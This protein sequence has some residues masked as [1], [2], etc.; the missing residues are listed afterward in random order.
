VISR[1]TIIFFLI[2]V[3]SFAILTYR[4]WEQER[5]CREWKAH[6]FGQPEPAPIRQPDGTVSVTL[7]PCGLWYAMPLVDMLLVLTGFSAGVAFVTSLIQD[8][9]RWFK[10]ILLERSEGG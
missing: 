7:N 10:R 6:H 1:R 8:I 3:T 2:F 5:P 9:V 4:R